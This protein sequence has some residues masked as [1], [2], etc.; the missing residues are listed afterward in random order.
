MVLRANSKLLATMCATRSKYAT[1]VLSCHASTE[2]MLVH[3]TAVVW[4]KCSFH[5]CCIL[6]VIF[7][8]YLTEKHFCAIQGAKVLIFFELTKKFGYFSIK[9]MYFS[10]F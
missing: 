5:C 1:T 10:L 8:S 6:F 2:T 9:K 4:L 3:A 7:D